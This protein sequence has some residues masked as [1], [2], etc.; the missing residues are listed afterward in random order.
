[1][2]F[3]FFEILFKLWVFAENPCRPQNI[4]DPRDRHLDDLRPRTQAMEVRCADRSEGGVFGGIYADEQSIIEER[5][6][7]VTSADLKALRAFSLTLAL[8]LFS[9]DL[10]VP[11]KKIGDFP[12]MPK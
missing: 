11:D 3:Y 7:E 5:P 10:N 8:K 4:I 9:D 1:M 6:R 2:R 12:P